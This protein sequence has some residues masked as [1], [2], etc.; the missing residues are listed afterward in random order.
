MAARANLFKIGLFG[1]IVVVVGA[2]VFAITLKDMPP[3]LPAKN[4]APE[5][6]TELVRSEPNT[7]RLPTAVATALGVQ[8][9][10]VEEAPPPVPLSLQ[11]SLFLDPNRLTH[12][13][14]RFAG[15][16]AEMGMIE[17]PSDEPD[18]M[19]QL[20]LRPVRF[21]DAVNKG[22]LLAVI[23]SKDLG[24]K[25]SELVDAL[26]RLFLDQE[27]A[28]RLDDLYRK[29]SIPERSLREAERN[30]ESDL[31]AVQKAERTL[32]TWRLT[33]AD[34]DEIRAEAARI[35]QN[36]GHWDQDLRGQW[37][38]V[39]VRAS[40]DGVVVE[41]NIAVGDVVDTALD[42]FK[43][44]DLTRLDVLAHVFE[45]DLPMLEDLPAQERHWNI[46]LKSDP[47]GKPLSGSFS[48]IG[49]I[50]DPNQHTALVMGWVDNASGRLR[51][52]QFVTAAVDLPA[53]TDEV[54]VPAAAIIDQDANSF[55][56]IQ[57]DPKDHRYTRRKVWVKR[58]RENL[59]YLSSKVTD[60]QRRAGFSAI[61]PGER[62]VVECGLELASQLDILEADARVANK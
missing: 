38:R 2:A 53:Y 39:E 30:V 34:I 48:Q 26:S 7:L 27:T 4:D 1:A 12:A 6:T 25:K 60:V 8:V 21:G 24:E 42:L 35:H 56:F 61:N 20:V 3:P 55:V 43:I 37:A 36:K 31:I 13:H 46:Y 51:I 59:I 52:G 44:A 29:G 32:L 54:A 40:I 62:V 16:V 41:K 50:I 23:W 14:T 33:K 19:G 57:S 10:V 18:Q 11:G 15:E 49:N 17:A 47:Q 28:K 45:E 58:R 5:E 9:N 22:Q